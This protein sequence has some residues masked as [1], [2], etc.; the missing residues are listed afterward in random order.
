LKPDDDA[1]AVYKHTFKQ[2]EKESKRK[3]KKGQDK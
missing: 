2:K 1:A 3:I